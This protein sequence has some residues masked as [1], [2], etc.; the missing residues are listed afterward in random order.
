M[1]KLLIV[2]L[3]VH[4][5]LLILLKIYWI[6]I[7]IAEEYDRPDFQSML[8][9]IWEIKRQYGL[10]AAYVD[11]ANPEIRQPIKKMFNEP[12][13][14]SYVSEKLTYCRKNNLDPAKR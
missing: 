2:L 12:Y 4:E 11:A 8:D 9:R 14:E 1:R 6:Q 10:S 13:S 5:E 7:V 3:L